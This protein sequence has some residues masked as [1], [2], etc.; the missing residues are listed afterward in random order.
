MLYGFVF[1]VLKFADGT[2]AAMTA[3]ILKIDAYVTGEIFAV[4][5]ELVINMGKRRLMGVSHKSQPP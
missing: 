3:A 4:I 2:P 1:E 5:L